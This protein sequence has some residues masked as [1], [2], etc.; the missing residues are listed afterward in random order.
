MTGLAAVLACL[1]FSP[2]DEAL[3]DRKLRALIEQLGA[4]FLEERDPARKALEKAGKSAEPRLIDAL[5]HADHRVR[6]SCLELLTL[7]KSTAALKRATDLFNVD[8]DPTVRDAAFRLIQSLGKDGEDSLIAALAS[9]QFEYRRGAI[10]TRPS[11]GS[12]AMAPRSGRRT[13]PTRSPR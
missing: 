6:R 7:L 3:D 1:V 9:P 10:Q 13:P 12:P 8:E 11:M 2:Q 5:G 4:D